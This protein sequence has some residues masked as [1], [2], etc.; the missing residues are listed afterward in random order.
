MLFDHGIGIIIA[1]VFGPDL[2]RRGVEYR[3]LLEEALVGFARDPLFLDFY[4]RYDVRV[5]VYGDAQR[6]LAGTRYA[7]ALNH[8]EELQ[9]RT[10]SHNQRR[11]FY[12]VCAH[13]ATETVAGLSVAFW[14]DCGRAPTKEEIVEMYF[15]EHVPPLDFFI[16][17]ADRHA[18]FDT[19]LIATGGADLYFTVSPSP[20]L[21]T[22]TLRAILF[23]HL[24]ARQTSEGYEELKEDDWKDL[25]RFYSLNREHV[26]GIGSQRCGV[27]L[28]LPQVVL[29]H[30]LRS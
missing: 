13:D 10:S 8:Y 5:R 27:W 19:P 4:D 25:R 28:P 18:V 11:L 30:H 3:N 20:Y 29:P 21:K 23:D 6:H 2:L 24:Y 26:Q 22:R 16:G 14:E 1:P 9:E 7:P 12:G 17:F 15:G